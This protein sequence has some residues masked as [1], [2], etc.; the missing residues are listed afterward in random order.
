LQ[1]QIII[2]FLL[3]TAYPVHAT[4]DYPQGIIIDGSLTGTSRLE[5][6]GPDY[7]IKA[8]YGRLEQT[9]LFH[10]FSQFN[11]HA[12]ERAVFS[13]PENVQNIISRITG[14]NVSWIDGRIES[15]IPDANFY[16]L[17]P[18]GVIFG[19]N[20]SLDISGSFYVSTADYLA[21]GNHGVFHTNAFSELNI[22]TSETPSAFGF[23]DSSMDS[24]IFE[25][26][27]KTNAS[28]EMGIHVSDGQRIS[29]IAGN[30]HIKGTWYQVQQLD[31]YGNP[32]F[33]P[34]VDEWGWPVYEIQTD[35]NGEPV[36]DQWGF[37]V[38]RLDENENPITVLALDENNNPI[39]MMETIYPPTLLTS[40]GKIQLITAGPE[41]EISIDPDPLHFESLEGSIHISEKA[42]IN[43]G[44][45]CG[46]DII[47]KGGQFFLNN[48]S[49]LSETYFNIDGGKID[50]QANDVN[51]SHG[52]QISA[53]TY[54]T[55]KGSDIYICATN[56]I[57]AEL[58][59]DIYPNNTTISALSINTM[60]EIETGDCGRIHLESKMITFKDSSEIVSSLK[61]NDSG[62]F[63]KA[64]TVFFNK[65]TAIRSNQYGSENADISIIANEKIVFDSAQINISSYA[66]L[67]SQ[68]AAAG[69]I[70]LKASDILFLD[71]EAIVS[72]ITYGNGGNM[73]IEGNTIS[74]LD[75]AY[76]E[77]IARD[78]GKASDIELLAQ[79]F[80]LFSGKEIFHDSLCDSSYIKMYASDQANL[81]SLLLHSQNIAFTCGAYI[82]AENNGSGKGAH[83]TLIADETISFDSF[84]QHW[85]IRMSGSGGIETVIYGE[86]G[87]RLKT[88]SLFP[89][90]GNAGSLLL[91]AEQIH[92]SDGA[93]IRVNTNGT[94]M[95]GNVSLIASQKILFDGEAT[96]LENAPTANDNY[97]NTKIDITSSGETINSGDA[98]KLVINADTIEFSNGAMINSESLGTGNAG[99]VQ[100]NA[101]DTISFFGEDDDNTV[102]AIHAS[103]KFHE[104]SAGDAG[105]IEIHAEHFRLSKGSFINSSSYGAGKGGSIHICA[106][107][108]S[109]S[110]VDHRG[111]PSN[112][113][114]GSESTSL[115][116]GDGGTIFLSAK[117]I[118]L[119][120]HAFLSTASKGNGKAGNIELHAES[121][122]LDHLAAV[123]SG[124]ESE[125]HYVVADRD[126]ID[127]SFIIAG[128]RV[129]VSESEKMYVFTGK[130][131]G[132]AARFTQ[133]FVVETPDALPQ[134]LS[135][136]KGDMAHVKNDGTGNPAD[137]ICILDPEF[138][139]PIWA[140]F[141]SDN[142]TIFQ[143]MTEIN[144]INNTSVLEDDIPPYANGLIKVLDT[145][146][147]KEGLFVCTSQEIQIVFPPHHRIN[148]MRTGHLNLDHTSRLNTIADQL[149]LENGDHFTINSDSSEYV[150]YNDEFIKL[151]NTVHHMDSTDGI[152]DLIQA[153]TG[154]FVTTSDNDSH[155]VFSGKNWIRPGT[156]D[157]I[158]SDLASMY[159][160]AA[161]FGDIV[162]VV[163][164]DQ[165]ADNEKNPG[166]F[167]FADNQWI[168]FAEGKGNDILIEGKNLFINNSRI[169]TSTF[170]HGSAA[171]ISLTVDNIRLDTNSS[172]AS[173]STAAKFGGSAGTIQ[174]QSKKGVRLL[175]NSSFSTKTCDAGGGKV[176]VSAEKSISLLNGKITSSVKQGA[177]EGGD[178]NIR[179]E[180]MLMNHGKI[181]ANADE[182]DGGAI[183]ITAD[184]FIKSADSP[185]EA[186][187]N[188]GNDGTVKIVAPDINITKGL[189]NLPSTLLNASRWLRT[190]CTRRTEKDSSRFII[191][192]RD[193]A[194]SRYDDFL[195][196]PP[197]ENGRF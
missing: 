171:N 168:P 117:K 104:M 144:Q 56:S 49:L 12:G 15:S 190:P 150:Y 112:I 107:E 38:Y 58:K 62:I 170:G 87:I 52:A 129:F 194:P 188:R 77:T 175:G 14:K 103:T 40:G 66:G 33:E 109:I 79:T 143:D 46:G 130:I 90:A 69:N 105:K 42:E 176:F 127:E 167:L 61:G 137:Y 9:N 120:S 152:F 94:G 63:L 18:S 89:H 162:Y 118:S 47:I 128:D 178:V 80:L 189:I 43:A 53:N 139:I 141:H 83:V 85:G 154:D 159:H 74:F 32:V 174:V 10:S 140:R 138:N 39:P 114:S 184:Y 51:L 65:D 148:I 23:I 60:T 102:S 82:E 35:E 172:I 55:G 179:S 1:K 183:F 16:L 187:S 48:S 57:V 192:G 22:L 88:N 145:G 158:V 72:L 133:Y 36:Y 26:G 135:F 180:L 191:K 96:W 185:I 195:A 3:A 100:L 84:I 173:E 101:R 116:P 181:T 155:F 169:S 59:N 34:V 67:N 147:G 54:G 28:P 76:I 193:A 25:G 110:G 75:G 153:Q 13:G 31:D 126:A 124:S 11:L 106:E 99:M 41:T 70:Y 119:S 146:N 30:I 115:L 98:G 50:I 45:L 71:E 68:P 19:K 78:S 149:V 196:S 91:D 2:F 86:T 21:L 37:P 8:E 177:G 17:N 95:G 160:I 134:G 123:T 81:P 132:G 165:N 20:A 161:E 44:G 27:E 136:S 131:S 7:Q 164:T 157:L 64:D 122:Y 113:Y 92:F 111:N 142:V 93:F 182:G 5:L 125:N 186:T 197:S 29:V 151:N 6:T 166:N 108:I 24:I 97:W 156:A 121:I 4:N 163:D 73:T